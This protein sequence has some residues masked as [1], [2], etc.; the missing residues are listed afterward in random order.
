MEGVD[1]LNVVD[2]L[3]DPLLLRGVQLNMVY[4]AVLGKESLGA[5]CIGAK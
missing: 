2:A 3:L 5:I 1:V 4:G